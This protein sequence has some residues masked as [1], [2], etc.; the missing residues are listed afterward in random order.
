[1]P[2]P[3]PLPKPASKWLNTAITKAGWRSLG[4]TRN[5][6]AARLCAKVWGLSVPLILNGYFA[7]APNRTARSGSVL[8]REA[9]MLAEKARSAEEIATEIVQRWYVGDPIPTLTAAIAS[10]ITAERERTKEAELRRD[11]AEKSAVMKSEQYVATRK[12]LTA[13]R[14]RAERAEAR[15]AGISDEL[16]TDLRA[17]IRGT[18]GLDV[19]GETYD[20][21]KCGW[22]C[23]HCG[24]TFHTLAGAEFHFGTV[25]NGRPICVDNRDISVGVDK[26]ASR[27]RDTAN[28]K[29]E[30]DVQRARAEAAEARI[31]ELTRP[32]GDA[33]INKMTITLRDMAKLWPGNGCPP[34][35]TI[36]WAVADL[37][38]RIARERNEKEAKIGRLREGLEDIADADVSDWDAQALQRCALAALNQTEGSDED[39]ERLERTAF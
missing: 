1:M 11:L 35:D 15:L 34:E 22:T 14:E 8:A 38:S 36:A 23:F 32:V 27:I 2:R 33:E 28:L 17:H 4:E 7:S 29:A 20:P 30:I 25:E 16:L 10:A 37:L 9:A 19:E 12:E 18:D 39:R 26:F 6:A 21:P 24:E 31:A 13:E 3:K 5:P